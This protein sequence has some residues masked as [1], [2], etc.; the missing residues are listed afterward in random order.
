MDNVDGNILIYQNEKGDTK[1]DVYFSGDSVWMTQK[2]IAELYQTSSQ[3]ITLH[4]KNIYYDRELQ[5]ES[6]CKNYLQV[7]R[8][9]NREVQ[10][11]VKI[12]NLQ[13]ILAIG[14]R[15]RNNIGMHFR[16][17]ASSILEEYM[18]KGFAMNDERLKNPK[19]FGEDYFDELLER[20]RDIRASEK[21]V[22]LKIK[23]IFATS[24]DYDPKSIQAE[25]FFK[26]VQN[27]LH[28]SVHGHTAAELIAERADASKDNMGLTAFK[29]AKVRKADVTIAKNYLNQEEISNLNRIVSMY[30][31]YAEDQAKQ[32]IP[33]YMKDWEGKLNTFLQFTGR[34]VLENA[35]SISKELADAL[36]IKQYDIFNENR[37]HKEAEIYDDLPELPQK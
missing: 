17:W 32:H 12:Y 25:V 8:E 1:V 13:M 20:I 11:K 19:K 37:R 30:L 35:G 16:N 7:Q 34:D 5:E 27:K 6:T 14:Y 23:D 4:I 29:G 21:R 33:M 18:K 2:S 26:T 36:A 9:G 22:Y 10:R 3:N 15:V 24:I 28:Y 31:D